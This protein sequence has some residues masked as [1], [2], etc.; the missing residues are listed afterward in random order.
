MHARLER[1]GTSVHIDPLATSAWN[2]LIHGQKRWVLFP[3]HVP[4]S[5]VKG[6]DLVRDDEDDEPIHYFMY[7][8]PRIKRKASA[9]CFCNGTQPQGSDYKDFACYEFTQNAGET[10]FIPN[11]WWHAVLNLSPT[12]GITQNFCS[13]RNFDEVWL[14]TRSGRKRLAW[15]WLC[16]LELRYPRLADRAKAMNA[17]DKFV[18]KYDPLVI[19]MLEK[20]EEEREQK[21]QWHKREEKEDETADN[22]G[23]NSTEKAGDD[24]IHIPTDGP[25]GATISSGSNGEEKGSN[26]VA[27]S[28]YMPST[29]PRLAF[30]DRSWKRSRITEVKSRPVSPP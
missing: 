1:S 27:K 14:K 9:A 3:P 19:E 16:Q 5:V 30:M 20:A 18:M 12:V 15:K 4:K 24:A 8:L 26:V 7:I 25:K 21:R 23:K 10:V 22:D 13:S 11:G 29:T 6:R 2:T 17:R 28:L